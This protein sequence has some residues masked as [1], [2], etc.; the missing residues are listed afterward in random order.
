MIVGIAAAAVTLWWIVKLG[1]KP[2]ARIPP[3]ATGRPNASA[4]PPPPGTPPPAATVQPQAPAVLDPVVAELQAHRAMVAK[5]S[6][7]DRQ[8]DLSAGSWANGQ[9][10]LPVRWNIAY[11]D[12]SGIIT[13]RTIQI[14]HL[15]LRY[16]CVD[17]YCETR[18]DIRTFYLDR[19]S[20][21]RDP[22]TGCEVDV[23]SYVDHVRRKRRGRRT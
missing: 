3:W 2:K 22:A 14:R 13:K 11:T 20:D 1:D 10:N 17:A 18:R 6:L 4:R 19:I 21:V 23:E 8:A 7:P 12:A 15:N 5:L 16:K 9:Y